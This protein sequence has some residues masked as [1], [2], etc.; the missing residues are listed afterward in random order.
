VDE[1]GDKQDGSVLLNQCK[2]LVRAQYIVKIV[3]E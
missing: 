1:G 2:S 3:F